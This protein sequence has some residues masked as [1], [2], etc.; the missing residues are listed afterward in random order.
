MYGVYRLFLF[1]IR[2]L[3]AGE[4]PGMEMLS[5]LVL[6][7]AGF[8]LLVRLAGTADADCSV[9]RAG[10]RPGAFLWIVLLQMFS[11]AIHLVLIQLELFCLKVP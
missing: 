10:I 3:G 9:G 4:L 11:L 8:L 1:V 7:G 6:Y 2:R 5:A